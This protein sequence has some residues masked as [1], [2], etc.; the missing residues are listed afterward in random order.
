MTF[1]PYYPSP[2]AAAIL[3]SLNRP[4]LPPNE[5]RNTTGHGSAKRKSEAMMDTKLPQPEPN[6]NDVSKSENRCLPFKKR[7]FQVQ[8]SEEMEKPPNTRVKQTDDDSSS[9]S[10][11]VSQK[12][13]ENIVNNRR[14]EHSVAPIN[15]VKNS[16]PPDDSEIQGEES[17][18]SSAAVPTGCH[19]RTTRTDTFCQRKP[20]YKGS[21]YCKLHYQQY[22]VFR[23]R[24]DQPASTP[25]Q[26]GNSPEST[27][28]EVVSASRKEMPS[29]ERPKKLKY[30]DKCFTTT[31]TATD[32][33]RIVGLPLSEQG[34]LRC[35]AT[36]SRGHP[37]AYVAVHNT[38]YCFMHA[39]YDTNPP[40]RRRPREAVRPKCVPILQ[41]GLD[42]VAL[43]PHIL[44][45]LPVERIQ[46]PLLSPSSI[47]SLNRNYQQ[48]GA[49][50]SLFANPFLG[51]HM[52]SQAPP[53]MVFLSQLSKKEWFGVQVT[54]LAGPFLYRTGI[55]EKWGNGW[56]SV[57]IANVHGHE[58]QPESYSEGQPEDVVGG[59]PPGTILH[60]RRA[61]ELGVVQ[62]QRMAPQNG[63]GSR[64]PGS[65]GTLLVS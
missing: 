48:N 21:N 39:D 51:T 3:S 60:N 1:L 13:F 5:P 62:P 22:V 16:S 12:R 27:S 24:S 55:V 56:V 23:I 61:F 54:I 40:R 65:S 46:R 50:P 58:S 49:G 52:Q 37:C 11:E 4:P 43:A 30:H 47:M 7:R 33:S 53:S 36:T 44:T 17:S 29:N 38:K 18:S 41:G 14:D 25:P 2:F 64:W 35:H 26:P 42:T 45:S 9:A 59:G 31:S 10:L 63:A 32:L 19:G 20:C 57:R 6:V 15:C 8:T 28:K 34:T